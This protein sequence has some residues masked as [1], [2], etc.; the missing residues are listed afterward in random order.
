MTA[1]QIIILT[2]AA[3]VFAVLCVA[4]KMTKGKTRTTMSVAAAAAGAGVLVCLIVFAVPH[5]WI[6]AAL[7]VMALVAVI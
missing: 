5:A 4:E 2:A 7:A 6:A 3:T 1:L